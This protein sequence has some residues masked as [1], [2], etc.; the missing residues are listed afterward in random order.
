MTRHQPDGEPVQ[1]QKNG[2]KSG[3][4]GRG[5]WF[6][7]GLLQAAVVLLW[8]SVHEPPNFSPANIGI[9]M[10]TAVTV[11]LLAK[12]IWILAGPLSRITMAFTRQQ[13]KNSRNGQAGS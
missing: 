8:A 9:W 4:S 12:S 3:K 10:L 5:M 6:K 11:A 7:P 2:H 13:L 1:P